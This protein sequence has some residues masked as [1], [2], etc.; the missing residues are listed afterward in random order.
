MPSP[1]SSNCPLYRSH[2]AGIPI[3]SLIRQVRVRSDS[4]CHGYGFLWTPTMASVQCLVHGSSFCP[5][6]V[7]WSY[8]HSA[9]F[10]LE[11]LLQMLNSERVVDQLFDEVVNISIIYRTSWITQLINVNKEPDWRD[12]L[13]YRVAV[14][15][16]DPNCVFSSFFSDRAAMVTS[17]GR[18]R[19][20]AWLMSIPVVVLLYPRKS[21]F[22]CF[23]LC[24]G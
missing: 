7:D 12:T 9:M 14:V 11:Q 13:S 8:H 22:A 17:L 19:G 6:S 5:S 21:I 10:S 23:T 15:S 3:A 4:D 24:A 2:P 20:I 18:I 1:A 16:S